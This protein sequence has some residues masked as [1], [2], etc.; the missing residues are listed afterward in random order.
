VAGSSQVRDRYTP[1]TD[2]DGAAGDGMPGDCWFDSCTA[3]NSSER[4]QVAHVPLAMTAAWYGEAGRFGFVAGGGPSIHLYRITGSA[5]VSMTEGGTP[6]AAGPRSYAATSVA[7]GGRALSIGLRLLAGTTLRLGE[8]GDDGG[9][10]G[11]SLL[12]GA[13]FAAGGTHKIS[14]PLEAARY[15]QSGKLDLEAE[16]QKATW[17]R[18][19]DLR[20][21]NLSYSLGFVWMR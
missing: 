8:L 4:V 2:A 18:E 11:L 14:A 12:T 17:N 21:T 20:G 16:A 10:W 15:Y 9:H 7:E 6:D 19:V 1:A 3:Y 13:D 5:A